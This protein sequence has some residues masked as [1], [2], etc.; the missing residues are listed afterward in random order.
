MLAKFGQVS[1]IDFKFASQS[2]KIVYTEFLS[3]LRLVA[4]LTLIM[5]DSSKTLPFDLDYSFLKNEE[6]K[7]EDEKKGF[8]DIFNKISKMKLRNGKEKEENKENTSTENVVYSFNEYCENKVINN[9]NKFNK[10]DNYPVLVDENLT[11]WR[12]Y[13]KLTF[14][15]CDPD[16]PFSNVLELPKKPEPKK[17]NEDGFLNLFD[18]QKKKEKGLFFGKEND[19][20]FWNLNNEEEKESKNPNQCF[21]ENLIDENY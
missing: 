14:Y 8:L 15:E 4:F 10:F 7:E 3:C 18:E 1:K 19:E 21:L 20:K 5:K 12:K 9:L 16:D 17:S 2:I 6:S 13:K 11:N